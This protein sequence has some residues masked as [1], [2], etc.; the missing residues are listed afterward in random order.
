MA[1]GP[2]STPVVAEPTPGPLPRPLRPIHALAAF[3]VMAVVLGSWV[4]ASHRFFPASAQDGERPP[5]PGSSLLAGWFHFDGGWYTDIAE[6]GYSLIPG[7][8]SNVAFFPAYP[9]LMRWLGPL[10]G[11]ATTAGV[12]ITFVCGATAVTLFGRWVRD[13]LPAGAQRYA[14][15]ALL[16]YP[17]SWFLYGAVYADA[18]FLAASLA[19]FSLLERDRTV[20]AGVLGFVAAATRPV[21]PAVVIGLV[22]RQLERRDALRY[23]DV[24]LP[25]LR[26]P[27][28]LP[29]GI[30]WHRLR[31]RDGGVLLSAG[32]FLAYS[33]FLWARWGDPLLFSTVQQYW[34]QE[35][36]PVTWFKLHLAGIILLEPREHALYAPGCV[37]QGIFAV[38]TLLLVPRLVRRFGWGYGLLVFFLVAVPVI[39][40]K[41]FQGLGRYLLASFPVFALTGEWLAGRSVRT[42]RLVVGTGAVLLA[43]WSHTYARGFYVS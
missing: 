6:A 27:V 32:G 11:S 35:A 22:V 43:F 5:F 12:A 29:V 18:L 14:L 4:W 21:G 16:L 15:V 2:L 10:F 36:G 38:G 9:L 42:R 28:R 33:G 17:Y 7:A 23:R 20:A 13:K 24:Q 39:G 41:D 19:A 8:Q 37:L 26:N 25:R 40:S 1:S 30:V 34:A 31:W 3:L